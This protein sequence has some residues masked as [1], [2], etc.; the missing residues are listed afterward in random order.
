MSYLIWVPIN[1]N[2]KKHLLVIAMSDSALEPILRSG[3]RPSRSF[4]CGGIMEKTSRSFSWMRRSERSSAVLR[5]IFGLHS[6]SEHLSV[7]EVGPSTVA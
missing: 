5:A 7:T 4:L 1:E 3:R 6:G 2:Y